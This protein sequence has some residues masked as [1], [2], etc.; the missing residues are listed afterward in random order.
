MAITSGPNLGL[1]VNGALDEEHYL[2]LMA[3]WR[4]IDGLVQCHVKDKDLSAPPGSPANG[5]MYIV[6]AAATGAWATHSG[7][8][9]RYFTVGTGAPAW[10]FFTPKA[11]WEA[12]VEDELTGG[13]PTLYIYSGFA[14]V[15]E[16]SSGAL[17]PADIGVTV[18]GLVG[19]LVP[20]VNLP[21]Y[22]DDV[23]EFA[24]FAAFP[25]T[26]ESGKIYISLAAG[27]DGLGPFPANQQFRW[28][29]SAYQRIVA[30]PGTTD[31]VPEGSTNKYFT[32]ARVRATPLTG[33]VA[34]VGLS[35]VVATDTILQA[36]QKVQ[37]WLSSLGT[38]SQANLVTSNT[39]TIAGR[40]PTVGWMGI[41]AA[42][43]IL[44]TNPDDA[45]VNGL[46]RGGGSTALG[47]YPAFLHMG[48]SATHNTQIGG[49]SLVAGQLLFRKKVAGV[50]QTPYSFWHSGNLV[51]TTSATDTTAGRVP[52][53]GWMG[54]G[55]GSNEF[56]NP[57]TVPVNG[58]WRGGSST[59]WGAFP[60]ILH[61]GDAPSLNTQ[62]G[63][64]AQ[65]ANRLSFRKKIDNVWQ[66]VY[67]LWHT[68]NTSADVQ[69][70]LGAANN[71]AL[72]AAIQ[73]AK[74]TT[75]T[76]SPLLAGSTT[77]GSATY[78][79]RTGRYT[80]QGSIAHIQIAVGW[81]AHSGT[82]DLVIADLPFTVNANN[83]ATFSVSAN[84]LI[85]GAGLVL[86]AVLGAS[87]TAIL[88][89]AYDPVTGVQSAVPLAGNTNVTELVI[90]GFYEI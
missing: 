71:A 49:P 76:F 80:E 20:S 16:S 50:W 81:S 9:A 28:G 63:G 85:L 22:V 58:F 12:R 14:W 38:A 79:T 57:D 17:M 2:P 13:V 83:K 42:G 62:I 78:T 65:V 8:L 19:G 23:L 26:G 44:L 53:V 18:A 88:L 10:Q 55:A 43:N 82:G 87:G 74:Y 86:Q 35:A 25:A 66:P 54:L 47:A 29:G 40:V 77:P 15:I 90:N 56:S 72:R 34:G 39:D 46:W 30:S 1:A 31:N 52:T 32:E 48:D 4:G 36:F 59:A 60:S 69:T 70:M 64:P 89:K 6:G 51:K 84:G 75:G 11:G 21:S 33:F 37:G 61:M 68:G 3:Q 67:D 5:D 73:V 41:G 7:K 24:N 45:P 27:T